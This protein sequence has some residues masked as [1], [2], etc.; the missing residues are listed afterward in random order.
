[1][2]RRSG[3]AAPAYLD[4]MQ[5]RM[6]VWAEVPRVCCAEHGVQQVPVPWADP[7]ARFTALFEAIVIDWLAVASFE[8]V[9]L[10]WRLS[11]DQVSGIQ[12]R[13][14]RRGLSRRV[15]AAS[16]VVGVDARRRS[17]GGTSM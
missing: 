2:A 15:V 16:P 9:A 8:A 4:T 1:M 12:E 11:W 10:Q 14:V 3:A 17:N 13:A 6:L 5:Y 7:R